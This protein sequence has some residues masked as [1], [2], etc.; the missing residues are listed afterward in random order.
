[1]LDRCTYIVGNARTVCGKGGTLRV[2][3]GEEPLE[4]RD[5][6]TGVRCDT[7]LPQIFGM[8]IGIAYAMEP[9]HT[10]RRIDKTGASGGPLPVRAEAATSTSTAVVQ[11]LHLFSCRR[12][13]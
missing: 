10:L 7:H 1:M 9:V 12:R 2:L 13:W 8:L 3:D 4:A 6:D 5:L 11:Q